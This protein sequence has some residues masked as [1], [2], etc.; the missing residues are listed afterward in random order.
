MNVEHVGKIAP[1]DTADVMLPG[2]DSSAFGRGEQP[3]RV[4][5]TAPVERRARVLVIS[6]KI[7]HSYLLGWPRS[8]TTGQF[9]GKIHRANCAYELRRVV[10][11]K[12][13]LDTPQPAYKVGQWQVGS[14]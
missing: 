11:P 12:I 2:G 5:T 14:A 3:T 6:H 1:A 4:A 9:G 10:P 7:L 13:D 8:T